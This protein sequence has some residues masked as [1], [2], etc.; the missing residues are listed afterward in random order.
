MVACKD[1]VL[2]D[3]PNLPTR[4]L[5][6]NLN[7][8]EAWPDYIQDAQ[9]SGNVLTIS[10]GNEE[11][12][13]YL[14]AS[15]YDVNAYR[16]KRV[17]KGEVFARS[18]HNGWSTGPHLHFEVWKNGVRIDPGAWLSN[19]ST[20]G[21]MSTVGEVEFNRLYIALFGPMEV[22]PPTEGDRKRWIGGE[23]N[24]V[25][26]SMD[27]DPRRS[28]WLQYIESLKQSSNPSTYKPYSGVTL[29]TKG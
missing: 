18:G 9:N 16:G 29:Y 3:L 7:N 14:H 6:G 28:A 8:W 5:M 20:G 17:S 15:P 1:G 12:T 21:S 10:H 26:R 19:I 2:T 4:K 25:I 23:T 22:N 11:Y 13:C 24:T 27:A